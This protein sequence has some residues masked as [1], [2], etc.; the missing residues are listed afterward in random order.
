MRTRAG[1]HMMASLRRCTTL[2]LLRISRWTAQRR[3]ANMC[4][5]QRCGTSAMGHPHVSR[6]LASAESPWQVG[7]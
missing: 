7:A 6:P 4:I 5:V 1:T 2:R 3:E